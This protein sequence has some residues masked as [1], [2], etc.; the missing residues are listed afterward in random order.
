MKSSGA[1]YS[2]ERPGTIIIKVKVEPRSSRSGISGLYGES[3][4][5]KLRSPP[6]EGKA[7]NE[8]ISVLAKKLGIKK[9]Q[10]EIISG[11]SS[12]NKIIRLTGV[13]ENT[14]EC[15]QVTRVQGAAVKGQEKILAR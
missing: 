10:I 3:L 4:K 13:E 8:I 2:L 9:S 14:L 15:L 6:V 5:V 1:F 11:R 7:N 12:K